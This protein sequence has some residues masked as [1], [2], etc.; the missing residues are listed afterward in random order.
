MNQVFDAPEVVRGLFAC[1]ECDNP[2][3]VNPAHLFL[4]TSAEN[5]A[6]KV[7]KGRQ[8]RG[9]S[10]AS[11]RL[12][13]Q[14]AEEIRNHS[15]YYGAAIEVANKYGISVGYAKA[16]MGGKYWKHLEKAP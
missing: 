3:C 1:H 15:H 6:D 13:A 7:A 5:T 4:G 14:Q 10:T 9:E 12:T 8:A 2:P 16:L 11:S